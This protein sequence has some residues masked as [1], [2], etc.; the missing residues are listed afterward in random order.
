MFDWF[1]KKEEPAPKPAQPARTWTDEEIQNDLKNAEQALHDMEVN[2]P[3]FEIGDEVRYTKV[4]NDLK[5]GVVTIYKGHCNIHTYNRLHRPYIQTWN[6]TVTV[7]YF[8]NG[9]LKTFAD[10]PEWFVKVVKE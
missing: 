7:G 1:N 8:V 4:P 9:E 3:T 5:L 2:F 6:S 10:S